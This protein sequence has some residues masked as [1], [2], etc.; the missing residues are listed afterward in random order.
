MGNTFWSRSQECIDERNT[1][2]ENYL[3]G[4]ADYYYEETEFYHGME[5]LEENWDTFNLTDEVGGL[6][7][8]DWFTLEIERGWTE[9][10]LD[11][12]EFD[13]FIDSIPDWEDLI[14][15]DETSMENQC[16]GDF[17]DYAEKY[18]SWIHEQG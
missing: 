10:C 12:S 18:T 7:F 9:G 13:N 5:I 15:D 1:M 6:D 2:Q 3:A 8:Y 11:R 14:Y 17:S 4:N 16:H